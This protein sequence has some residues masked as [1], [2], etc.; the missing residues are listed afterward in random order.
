MALRE[1]GR[2]PAKAMLPFAPFFTGLSM[3]QWLFGTVLA[4][5]LVGC[6]S[7]CVKLAERICQCQSNQVDRD[8]CNSTV[9]ARASQQ[10]IDSA[11]EDRC[12]ALV[13]KCDCHELNTPQGKQNCG[14]ANP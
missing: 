7:P 11:T 9:S 4:G 14:L 8:N 12:A 13:D 2:G 10:N 5:A 1:A 3:K 6:A